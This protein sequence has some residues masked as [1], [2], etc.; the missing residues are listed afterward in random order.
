MNH[1]RDKYDPITRFRLSSTSS[2]MRAQY[3]KS[4]TISAFEHVGRVFAPNFS[5]EYQ[6]AIKS[7]NNVFRRPKGMCSEMLNQANKHNFI[8]TT[9]G[10]R[11]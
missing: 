1:T 4:Q 11:S 9:F 2:G 7:N 10:A 5:K 3:N 8:A 6:N